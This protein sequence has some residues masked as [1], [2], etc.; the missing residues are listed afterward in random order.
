VEREIVLEGDI[1]KMYNSIH[2]EKVEQHCHRFLWR[3]LEERPPDTYIIQR[4]SM[5][6]RPAAAN[7]TEAIYKTAELFESQFPYVARLLK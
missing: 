1:R 6:D 5:G 3:D 4:V 7:N 2:I